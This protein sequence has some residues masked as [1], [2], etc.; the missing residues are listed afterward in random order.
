MPEEGLE[1]RT[2]CCRGGPCR[3]LTL[4]RAPTTSGPSFAPHGSRPSCDARGA[5]ERRHAAMSAY[6]PCVAPRT[7]IV[8][9]AGGIADAVLAAA[10]LPPGQTVVWEA[11]QAGL[12]LR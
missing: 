1:P 7:I 6:D 2:A 9:D 10:G 11:P 8:L 3:Q 12:L 5:D 4:G